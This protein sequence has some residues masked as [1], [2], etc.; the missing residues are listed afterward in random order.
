MDASPGTMKKAGLTKKTK[1]LSK[2]TLNYLIE[3][4]VELK[5]K[6]ACEML[7]KKPHQE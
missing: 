4:A 3:K 6:Q 5:L 7:R 1:S 2:S